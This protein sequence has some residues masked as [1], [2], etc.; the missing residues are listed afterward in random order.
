KGLSRTGSSLTEGVSTAVLGKK[1]IDDDVL[2]ELET[3]LLM[4]DV[5]MEATLKIIDKLAEKVKRKE[6]EDVDALMQAMYKVMIKILRPVSV[7]LEIEK[8]SEEKIDAAPLAKKTDVE[9]WATQLINEDMIP[10]V[11]AAEQMTLKEEHNAPQQDSSN[12]LA[13]REQKKALS[14]REKALEEREA[15]VQEAEQRAQGKIAELLQL[16]AR[17]QTILAEEQSIKDKKIKRLTAV[18]EGMKAERAAPVIAQMDL[19]IVVKIF[20]RMSEKQVGKIL[21]FLQP[22]QAV[23]ISQALTERIA[24]VK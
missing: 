8:V 5:G 20:S 7:P 2:E 23:V 15:V 16:E 18:Y 24:S 19:S 22:K 17:I 3:R 4:A 12:L 13:L 11:E 21:S 9:S 6:L 10:S 14:E 1:Q